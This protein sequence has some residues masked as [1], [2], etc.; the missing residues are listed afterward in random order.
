M[1]M[2]ISV[3][4]ISS[5]TSKLPIALHCS[6]GTIIRE[7]VISPMRHSFP[8]HSDPMQLSTEFQNGFHTSKYDCGH[9]IQST[10][11]SLGRSLQSPHG[12]DNECHSEACLH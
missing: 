11:W 10:V 6:Q 3:S 1:K 5:I 9:D 8:P 4:T 12:N 7:G 2:V